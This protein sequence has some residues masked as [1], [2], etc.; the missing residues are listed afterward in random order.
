MIGSLSS[1]N[2]VAD[3][4]M[5]FYLENW[6]TSALRVHLIKIHLDDGVTSFTEELFYG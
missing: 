3:Y 4:N 1:A 5:F 6:G 2:R